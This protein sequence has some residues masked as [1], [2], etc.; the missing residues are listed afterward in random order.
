[1]DDVLALDLVAE[2]L[3]AER[4]LVGVSPVSYRITENSESF[5]MGWMGVWL[6]GFQAGF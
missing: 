2:V 5:D 1:M 6:R 4:C 3:Q